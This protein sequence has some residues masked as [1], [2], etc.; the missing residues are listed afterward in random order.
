MRNRLEVQRLSN[1][2]NQKQFDGIVICSTQNQIVN[3][4]TI[5]HHLDKTD[6]KIE[7]YYITINDEKYSKFDN[8]GWDDNIK[9]LLNG[10]KFRLIDFEEKDISDHASIIGR[11]RTGDYGD[12]KLLWNITGGQRHLVMAITD[13]VYNDRKDQD[14][15]VYYEGNQR[16]FYYY[17]QSKKVVNPEKLSDLPYEKLNLN[18][19]FQLMGFILDDKTKE[20]KYYN[21][22]RSKSVEDFISCFEIDE[23]DL[24][25]EWETIEA[26]RRCYHHLFQDF[27]NA[28]NLDLLNELKLTNNSS[29]TDLEQ[30]ATY[31]MNLEQSKYF[32][33]EDIETFKK[34]LKSRRKTALFGYIFEY[35]VFYKIINI[36][37]EKEEYIQ[38]IADIHFS[39][40]ARLS[41]TNDS[42]LG[43]VDEFDISILTKSGQLIIFECKSGGFTGDNIKSHHYSTCAV[44]GVYGT[45]VLMIPITKKLIKFNEEKYIK[46]CDKKIKAAKKAKVEFWR[47]DDLEDNLCILLEREEKHN[48]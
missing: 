10:V 48:V 44:S 18:I 4:L 28:V 26:E 3:Y 38:T 37:K 29:C 30:L 13:F 5:L 40:E 33:N 45:P 32:V 41:E 21:Y 12:K 47:M 34:S 22:L 46:D 23:D 17:S 43:I 16:K 39:A 31:V 15:I 42:N 8:K 11:L 6:K 20:S 7:I 27:V 35:M 19:A 2:S 36:I 1:K 14:V 9:R 25:S 24:Q